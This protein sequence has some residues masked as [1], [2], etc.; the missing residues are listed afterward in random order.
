MIE[1]SHP[2]CNCGCFIFM[3][4]RSHVICSWCQQTTFLISFIFQFPFRLNLH[5]SISLFIE[6]IFLY[7]CQ[8]FSTWS[9]AFCISAWKKVFCLAVL[10]LVACLFIISILINFNKHFN[11]IQLAFLKCSHE[12]IQNFFCFFVHKHCMKLKVNQLAFWQN[13]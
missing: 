3:I 4:L 9:L 13:L 1:G 7:A 11:A 5:S 2:S 8:L 6:S 10:K 12:A